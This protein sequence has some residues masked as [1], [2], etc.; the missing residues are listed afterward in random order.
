[1]FCFHGYTG[2]TE[3]KTYWK[4]NNVGAFNGMLL[5]IVAIYVLGDLWYV[6]KVHTNP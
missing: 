3:C 5:I 6:I 1:M 4:T 2:N